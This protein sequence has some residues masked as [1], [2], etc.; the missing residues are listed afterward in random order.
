[1]ISVLVTGILLGLAAGLA[2]G[3]LS[4]L[5]ITETLQQNVKAGV[6]VAL[7]PLI[8]DLPI[9]LISVF[10]L[11]K[12]ANSNTV[13]GWISIAGA[14]FVFFIGYKTLTTKEIEIDIGASDSQ[15]LIKG[16]LANVLSPNPYLFWISVGSPI[17]TR[18]LKI[19]TLSAVLFLLGFYVCL[20]GSKVGLAWLAGKSKSIAV[21]K[22]YIY[23]MRFLGLVL[24]ILAIMLLVDGLELLQI[25]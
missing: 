16:M 4:T 25:V 24:G 5:V 3:P 12:I 6:K 10:V 20:V 2:P 11:T 8:T 17:M 14:L 1:V 23:T 18:A 19:N 22:K 21:G 7:A 15:S 13:L 9:I